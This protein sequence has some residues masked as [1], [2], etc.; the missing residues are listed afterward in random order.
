M[1]GLLWLIAMV[2]IFTAPTWL[3]KLVP[4]RHAS[5]P[6]ELAAPKSCDPLDDAV[7]VLLEP[8]PV[9]VSDVVPTPTDELAAIPLTDRRVTFRCGHVYAAA[10]MHNFY[11]ELLQV[12]PDVLADRRQCGECML[13]SIAPLLA[14]C[15]RCGFSIVPGERVTVYAPEVATDP[16]WVTKTPDGLGVIGC[17]RP[18]CGPENV[19]FA[20]YWTEHGFKPLYLST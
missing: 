16:A 4:R 2:V 8:L 12:W 1:E 7:E 20:G 3:M 19:R 6:R 13:A 9:P 15:A 10:F 5:R 18:N 17:L 11:G 14:R